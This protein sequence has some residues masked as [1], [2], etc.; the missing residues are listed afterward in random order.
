VRG[1]RLAPAVAAVENT[2]KVDQQ[3]LRSIDRLGIADRI[4]FFDLNAATEKRDWVLEYAK[5][6]LAKDKQAF[7]KIGRDRGFKSGTDKILCVCRILREMPDVVAADRLPDAKAS[8]KISRAAAASRP[9]R[10]R[11]LAKA[12]L[13]MA[14]TAWSARRAATM[15]ARPASTSP[16]ASARARSAPSSTPRPARPRRSE[17]VVGGA[18][19]P[20]TALPARS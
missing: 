15:R 3:T 6:L 19:E 18:L 9:R 4:I 5:E 11:S 8:N 20:P 17:R 7:D 1:S 2:N 10:S 13:S 16:R 12:T 14:R